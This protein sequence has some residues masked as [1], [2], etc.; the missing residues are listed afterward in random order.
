MESIYLKEFK[1]IAHQTYSR[2]NRDP[3]SPSYGS[4]DRAYWGWKYKDF[5]DATLQFGV[6]LAIDLSVMENATSELP[7]LLDGFAHYIATIQLGDG[8]F[9]QCYPNE[10]TPG[11][12]Y[13]ILSTLIYV[14]TS[15]FLESSEAH[16]ILDAAIEKSVRFALKSD[17]RHGLVTNHIAEFAYELF[18]YAAYSGDDK[19][20][21]KG[22]IYMERVMYL[23]N[24]REGWFREYDGADPGYQ[25]RTLRY[26][27]KSAELL[28]QDVLWETA[29]KAADFVRR[30][31][32]PDGTIHPMLGCRSTALV[33]PSGFEKLAV[34]YSS[35]R[36][37][38]GLVRSGW[39]NGLTPLPSWLDFDN[40]IRL[41]DDALEAHRAFVEENKQGEPASREGGR[42]LIPQVSLSSDEESVNLEDAGI[43][44]V[45]RSNYVLFFGYKLGGVVVIY[46]RSVD[47]WRLIYEDSGFV[48]KL[49]GNQGAWL[50]RMPDS[51]KL[52][53][54]VPNRIGMISRFYNSLHDE[55][56]PLRLVGLRILNLTILG[57]IWLG[58]LFRKIVVRRLMSNRKT[59]PAELHR[60]VLMSDDRIVIHDR[61]Q[62]TAN[63][64][65]VFRNKK[66]FRCRRVTGAHMASSRYFQPYEIKLQN[67]PWLAPVDEQEIIG[68]GIEIELQ[69]V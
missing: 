6:R 24:P 44:I 23:Y 12:V 18:N 67:S 37:L 11:V 61:I 31:M 15:P 59:L 19:A 8:S 50:N 45:R 48:V 64:K 36:D 66:I 53:A 60:D 41:A 14:K 26:L 3:A 27:T 29:A 4:F 55:V 38:A 62:L 63:W 17:E 33:Y 10:R 39:E 54:F 25:T 56:T 69:I 43:L 9:N 40:A 58:D 5:S 22:E 52:T 42:G 65:T 68:N 2:W 49:E 35:Y 46:A 47:G 57:N 32:M 7:I 34:K 20:R 13:D 16:G 28:N 21:I 1:N 30:V 51:G